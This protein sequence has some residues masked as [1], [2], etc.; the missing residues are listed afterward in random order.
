MPLNEIRV[1]GVP[2]VTGM[3]KMVPSPFAPPVG[4]PI[5][6]RSTER[7]TA[8]GMLAVRAVEREQGV[9]VPPVTG[10]LKM[11]PSSFARQIGSCHKVLIR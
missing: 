8:I 4:H 11:V 2:P 3:L 9:G 6:C 1:V 10:M 5:K 7:Q